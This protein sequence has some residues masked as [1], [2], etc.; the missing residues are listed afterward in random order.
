[1]SIYVN[2]WQSVPTVRSQSCGGIVP[3]VYSVMMP[4]KKRGPDGH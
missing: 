2:M 1:M 4:S 3:P